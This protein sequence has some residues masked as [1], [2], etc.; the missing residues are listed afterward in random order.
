MGELRDTAAALREAAGDTI[1]AGAGGALGTVP[2]ALGLAAAG[3]VLDL[4]AAPLREIGG[5]PLLILC[6]A[7]IKP[8][9]GGSGAPESGGVY[10]ADRAG[11][12]LP[13]VHDL[14]PFSFRAAAVANMILSPLGSGEGGYSF[15]WK[16]GERRWLPGPEKRSH[17]LGSGGDTGGDTGGNS[18]GTGR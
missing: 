10:G 1:T 13:A 6:A 15:A 3:P 14:L 9:E 8:G 18:A 12:A 4:P 2:I 7:L 16:I 11:R 17:A 5:F